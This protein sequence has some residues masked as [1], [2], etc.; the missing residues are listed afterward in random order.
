[1]NDMTGSPRT[2]YFEIKVDGHLSDQRARSF[3]GLPVARLPNGE[4]MISGEIKDQSELFGILIRIRDMGI[5]LLSVNIKPSKI[6]QSL[7]DSK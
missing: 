6:F 1:M 4:T 2:Q 7:G 3:E 5:P